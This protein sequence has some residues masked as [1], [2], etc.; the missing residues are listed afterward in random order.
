MSRLLAITDS[1]R[2]A[3]EAEADRL[4]GISVLA[5][6]FVHPKTGRRVERELPCDP[7]STEDGAD[8]PLTA[9]ADARGAIIGSAEE[10]D[11]ELFGPERHVHRVQLTQ[12]RARR[13][14]IEA[15]LQACPSAASRQHTT[16]ECLKRLP[17]AS[18]L[19]RP[20]LAV[21]ADENL[22][23]VGFTDAR[24]QI[25]KAAGISTEQARVLI[26]RG[27]AELQSVQRE[28]DRREV[29]QSISRK[30]KPD[31]TEIEIG[32]V[33]DGPTAAHA[34]AACDP[35]TQH[36]LLHAV[37]SRFI[38][39]GIDDANSEAKTRRIRPL[40]RGVLRALDE[41]GRNDEMNRDT[42]G[43]LE[44]DQAQRLAA[45]LL[46]ARADEVEGR[47]GQSRTELTAL[48]KAIMNG[49]AKA[50]IK[51][52]EPSKLRTTRTKRP[53]KAAA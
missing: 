1:E 8:A 27:R 4:T 49:A 17:R 24:E 15:A 38:N 48:L 47:V 7:L 16:R 51:P 29:A 34:I 9:I 18:K 44:P 25:A 5:E 12:L 13:R 41:L 26:A 50:A 42:L 20:I 43:R 14:L 45:L 3:A 31:L 6:S 33:L 19:E 39:A 53:A 32:S 11:A 21:W 30:S 40:A 37:E 46:A 23:A 35:S 28:I 10:T 36:A 2:A 52:R 22:R